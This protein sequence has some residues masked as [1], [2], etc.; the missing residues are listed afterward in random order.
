MKC[1]GEKWM[2]QCYCIIKFLPKRRQRYG[3]EDKLKPRKWC[4]E[5]HSNKWVEE[6]TKIS[7][8]REN[9]WNDMIKFSKSVL[10]QK[11][12]GQWQKWLRSILSNSGSQPKVWNNL[13][14]IYKELLNLAKN[15][16]FFFEF[17]YACFHRP[18]P[19][20]ILTLKLAAQ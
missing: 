15:S 6:N 7:V 2:V 5:I 9:T 20:F 16:G 11:Q 18:L 14:V 10:S 19:S 1:S 13:K 8:N 17:S 4:S 3:W 12:R